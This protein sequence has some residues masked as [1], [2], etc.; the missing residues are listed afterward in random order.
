MRKAEIKNIMVVFADN[1]FVCVFDW[2]GKVALNTITNNNICDC[3]VLE[4]STDIE[5]FIKSLLPTAIEFLQYRTD[6]YAKFCRYTNISN[7]ELDDLVKYFNNI[8]FIY[9]FSKD[10]EYYIEG[11]SEIL[12]I[13]LE[14]NTSYI[15]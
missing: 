9:N 2:I 10:H 7:T 15:R 13:D 11:G 14:L 1:D 3:A 8:E 12:I 4:E 6:K 5:N